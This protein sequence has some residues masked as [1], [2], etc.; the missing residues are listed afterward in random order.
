MNVK[1]KQFL[2]L[3]AD[4]IEINHIIH[5]WREEH[6]FFLSFLRA[7]AWN[8]MQTAS[9]RIWTWVADSISYDENW[10]AKCALRNGM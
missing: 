10:Y 8:E 4:A 9:S 6:M 7:L 5:S 2:N 3:S 1:C